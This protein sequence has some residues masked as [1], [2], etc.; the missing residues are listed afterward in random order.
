[1][2]SRRLALPLLAMLIPLLTLTIPVKAKEIT[3]ISDHLHVAGQPTAEELDAF[4]QQGGRHVIDLR[5]PEE[6]PDFNEAAVVT[7]AGMAYYNIP[8]AGAA[9]LTRDNVEQL[10]RTLRRL[11]GETTLLHC[12]SS[13]RVGA[14]MALRARWLYDASVDEALAIGKEHGMADLQPQVEKLL[15]AQ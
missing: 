3:Q 2:K 4:A 12:S 13:N 10:D 6:T 7:R 8:I 11:E 1:M 9:G 5:P 14:L 15:T